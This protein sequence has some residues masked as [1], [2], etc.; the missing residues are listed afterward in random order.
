MLSF[1]LYF[2]YSLCTGFFLFFL[3]SHLEHF[4]AKPGNYSL[5]KKSSTKDVMKRQ[6]RK[7]R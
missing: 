5:E 6:N 2:F 1:N 7:Y 3:Q 4:G